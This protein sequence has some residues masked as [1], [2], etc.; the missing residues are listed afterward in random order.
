MRAIIFVLLVLVAFAAAVP[1]KHLA[2]PPSEFTHHRVPNP[3]QIVNV[4][5]SHT[6]Y[7]Y[8]ESDA[9][10]EDDHVFTATLPVPV[11]GDGEFIFT[12][13]S[14]YIEK[15]HLTMFD[16]LGNKLDLDKAEVKD[17]YPLGV[18]KMI[19]INA[20][21][22]LKSVKGFYELHIRIVG[23]TAEEIKRIE[24]RLAPDALVTVFNNDNIVIESHLT[25]MEIS[26]GKKVGVSAKMARSSLDGT[27]ERI[28]V[29]SA[30]LS[31]L[32][33]D[34][35]DL[36]VPMNDNGV[37]G[38][39]LANDGIFGAEFTIEAAGEYS[40]MPTLR[41]FIDPS[42]IDDPITEF[43]RSSQHL[44]AVSPAVVTITGRATAALQS[45]TR[46]NIKIAVTANPA[47]KTLRV[48]TEVY[49]ID[50]TSIVPVAWVG[51]L[52]DV[53]DGYVTVEL[54]HNWVLLAGAAPNFLLRNTYLADVDTNF[55]IATFNGDIK[56]EA[57]TPLGFA[58]RGHITPRDIEI[59][60]EMRF[61]VNPLRQNLTKPL[62]ADKRG[63]VLV[64]GYCAETN[65][66]ERNAVDFP[67]GYFFDEASLNVPNDEYAQKVINFA[68]KNGLTSF[69]LIGHSQGGK[70][71]LH[72]HNYYFSALEDATGPR[73]IQSV[74]SPY[75]GS[76]AAGN[77]ADLGK[78]L[79][80]AG[81]GSN[82]DLTREGA[83]AWLTGI[84]MASRGEVYYYTTTYKSGNLFGDYCSLPM[85]AILE[86]PNDAVTELKFAQLEGGNNMGNAEKWCHTTDLAYPA[87][88]DDHSRNQEMFANAAQ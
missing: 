19:P 65:P 1:R 71:A 78:V 86:W 50:G 37:D 79:G 2:G 44:V 13:T 40:M 57:L 29:S 45:A 70:V 64:P 20:Y 35:Q 62:G 54:D 28:S 3:S 39:L 58:H 25:T 18:G 8:L 9:D 34:G 7:I 67:G 63:V 56:V 30:K 87:Q 83:A 33:P 51:G 69:G 53:V 32:T 61:G 26:A 21:T 24:S 48:Y 16:P 10:E 41:G 15:S 38:D 36:I 75:Q 68:A 5:H 80:V 12:Y 74:G 46:T 14:A 55:P 73:L 59:T 82:T 85:N 60:K 42:L 22:I 84:N 11:D 17:H 77:I 72:I 27:K 49:S 31:M 52:V 4:E 6:Q 43:V 76:T 23:L 88:Y 47:P 81:C 66:W